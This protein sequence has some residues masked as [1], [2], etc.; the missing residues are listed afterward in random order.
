MK[1]LAIFLTLLFVAPSSVYDF[2]LKDIDGQGFSLAKYKGKKVLDRKHSI[3]M[4]FYPTVCRTA[5]IS[6]PVQRQI[7]CCWFPGK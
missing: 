3:K 2:K 4:W 6:R 7:G 5:K 1:I